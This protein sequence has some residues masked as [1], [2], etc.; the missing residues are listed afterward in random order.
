MGQTLNVEGLRKGVNLFA[1]A[2]SML[3]RLLSPDS[4]NP[5]SG[6][7]LIWRCKQLVIALSGAGNLLP[8]YM[9]SSGHSF[10]RGAGNLIEGGYIVLSAG[11]D[12][13]AGDV[14]YNRSRLR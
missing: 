14:V 3:I 10:R 11:L 12:C 8:R 9:P 6:T 13:L 1:G 5:P 7:D 4:N 2:V